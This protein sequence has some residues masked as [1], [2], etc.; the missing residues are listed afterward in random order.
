[1]LAGHYWVFDLDGTL[2]LPVHDFAFIRTSLEVPDGADILGHLAALP[3]EIAQTLHQRLDVIER[4]L[5]IRTAVAPGALE[6]VELLARRGCR[7]GILTRN[8]REIA[9]LTLAHIGLAGYFPQEGILGRDEA[10]PKPDPDG[11]Y[12]LARLWAKPPHQL[13]M[14]GDYLFDLQAGQAAGA[15]TIHV[16]GSLERRWPEWTDLCVASLGELTGRVRATPRP[17][18]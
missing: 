1:M 14:V 10:L 2:T 18:P 7:L 13:V 15:A 4:E 5:V 3:A 16:H 17:T 12:R 6:F 11:I 8:T 9:V